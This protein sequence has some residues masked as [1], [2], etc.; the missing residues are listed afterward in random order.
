MTTVTE[1]L[2]Q[3]MEIPS[4]S[5]E[6]T[7]VCQFVFD[8]LT[9]EGFDV[10]KY[11][12]DGKRFNLVA[13]LQ[14]NPK[15][16]LQAHLDTVPPHIKFTEDEENIYGR[17][18]CDTKGSAASM[19]TAAIQAKE[20]GLKNFGLI[21]TVGEE[22]T[23]DGAESLINSGFEVPF[24]TVGEPSSL[25][26]VNE[27]FGLLVIKIK[28]KG[29]SAHSSRPEEGINAIDLLLE[30]VQKIKSL[31]IHPKTLMSL[32]Q[33]NGGIADNIIPGDANA[34]FSFRI[35]P[36]DA[37]NYFEQFSTFS[38]DKIT[39]EKIIGVESVHTDV[40]SELDFIKVRRT[41]KYF[42][43]LS[44]FKKGVIIGP[45]DIKY[46]HGPDVKVEKGELEKAVGIYSE[47]IQNFE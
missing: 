29:K 34:T 39:F 46:S 9:K 41:V 33:I 47:I 23:L 26:I 32:V 17:G 35:A 12:V 43:E 6:E 44:F 27:H 28:V 2:K 7:N 37:I 13:T 5:G 19:I 42:T 22:T 18:A 24:V 20:K 31:E 10:K 25:E 3:L 30:V 40:P 8:L 15:V 16:Y 45:G 4:T 21:F 36:G 1:L 11:P 38:S 14:P